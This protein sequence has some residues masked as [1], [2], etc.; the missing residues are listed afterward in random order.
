MKIVYVAPHLSCGGC[1]QVILK[2][3]QALML[4]VENVEIYLI[5]HNDYGKWF[6]TQRNQIIDILKDR[7]YS[8][9]DDKMQ[10]INIINEINPNLIHIDEMSER[11]DR[12]LITALY[13]NNRTYRIVE[14][15]HDI[16]FDPNSKIFQPDLFL[17]C[18]PYHENTFADLDSQYYTIQYPIDFKT[19]SAKD[20]ELAKVWLDMDVDKKHILNVGIWTKG[21]N[22]SEGLEIA[23]QYPDCMFHF[24]GAQASNFADYWEPLM[25][26]IPDNVKIWGERSDVEEFMTAA[27][28]FMFNSTWECNPLVLRE[29]SA[30]G[31]PIMARNLPQYGDMFQKYLDPIHSDPRTLTRKYKF[32][33]ST[34]SRVYALEHEKSYDAIVKFP[35]RKQ[36]VQITQNFISQPFLE[37]K[38]ISDSDFKV[39][40][41]DEKGSMAYENTIKANSWV[42]L[43]RQYYTRWTAKVFQDGEL[44]YSNTLNLEGKEVLITI[45]SKA[46]GDT[47]AFIPYCEAFQEKHKCKVT[48]STFWNKILDYPNLKFIEPGQSI[49]CFA[50]YHLG[51]FHD[52]DKEPVPANKVPLQQS[53][54]NILGLDY[55]ELVPKVKVNRERLDLGR[56]VAIAT[57]ST[58]QCK[59]WQRADWQ[60]LIN[61]LHSKG[62]RVINVSRE[63]NP[64]D[65]CEPIS[66]TSIE[67]T[68]QVIAGA[69]FM[70]GLSSGLS[71]LSFAI[72]T[73]VVLIANFT[74]V[75]YEFSTNCTRIVNPK[76]CHDCWSE[77]KLD[78]AQWNW[79]PRNQNFICHTSI[80]AQMVIDKLPL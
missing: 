25:K 39:Q 37:I 71:W 65:N 17:F 44:I 78:P 58:A 10:A 23:R 54:S 21:K 7:F 36:C 32:V 20:K 14:T 27:D 68:M 22:Q 47:M 67:Y 73:H 72:G 11:L 64:F 13:N 5:E 57:N 75:D 80:T 60:I 4:Y 41:L 62:Y 28:V 61:Y 38:G 29:A 34:N 79:C 66:N 19:I 30:H 3:I 40:F 59:F 31:L 33:N 49:G 56:Y 26:D 6:P 43:N 9:G 53:A 35:I 51:Y 24:V 48:V 18:S 50:M 76:V 15:C 70:V 8:L 55:V 46:L 42:K 12:G 16:S 2:R 77:H 45:D 69:E 74:A 63:N 1:P 52:S